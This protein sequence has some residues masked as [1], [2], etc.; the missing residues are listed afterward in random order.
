MTHLLTI[1]L[2]I[3]GLTSRYDANPVCISTAI[4]SACAVG[5]EPVGQC[6]DAGD[7]IICTA[8][9]YQIPIYASWYDPVLGGINCDNSCDHKALRQFHPAQYGNSAAC[10]HDW[11][12]TTFEVM[13][14][15]ER[16]YCDDRGGAIKL[17]WRPVWTAATGRYFTWAWTVD[18]MIDS[19]GDVPW[20][21]YTL[22]DW[23]FTHLGALPVVVSEVPPMLA[24]H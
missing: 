21:A 7:G 17:G 14:T 6:H 18:F 3:T 20:W 15:G 10:P 16:W 1:A 12:A 2:L 8:H 13:V 9:P 4:G 11:I 23:R 22:L 5:A 24:G 19:T